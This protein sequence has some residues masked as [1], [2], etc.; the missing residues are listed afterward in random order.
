LKKLILFLD[1]AIEIPYA[2]LSEPGFIGLND[3]YDFPCTRASLLAWI[4]PLLVLS[5]D[6][7][8]VRPKIAK[9]SGVIVF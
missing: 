2:R 3:S 4:P 8:R 7:I 5:G 9:N 1:F 6:Y